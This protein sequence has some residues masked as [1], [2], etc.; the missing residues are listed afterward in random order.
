VG[1]QYQSVAS[2]FVISHLSIHISYLNLRVTDDRKGSE[3]VVQ[4]YSLSGR[5]PKAD[6][7]ELWRLSARSSQSLFARIRSS[8]LPYSLNALMVMIFV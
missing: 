4:L 6:V 5:F 7:L 2:Q 8:A 3:A 1:S